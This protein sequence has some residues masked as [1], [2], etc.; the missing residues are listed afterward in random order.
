MSP[1][2]YG[3]LLW[4]KLQGPVTLKWPPKSCLNGSWP[5]SPSS[6]TLLYMSQPYWNIFLSFKS[7]RLSSTLEPSTHTAVASFGIFFFHSFPSQC[8]FFQISDL[9]SKFS[10]DVV[11]RSG[12]CISC[13]NGPSHHCKHFTCHFLSRVSLCHST[14]NLQGEVLYLSCLQVYLCAQH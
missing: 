9:T 10:R 5:R 6:P 14:V 4:K 7:A 1:H 11:A 13:V 8:L 2:L 3:T 12:A